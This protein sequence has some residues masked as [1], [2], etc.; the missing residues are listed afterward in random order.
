MR[1]LF[2]VCC[3][4][5]AAF[6][7]NKQES[8]SNTPNAQKGFAT[9][10]GFDTSYSIAA[11]HQPY[12]LTG[13]FNDDQVPDTAVILKEKAGLN[14]VLL[15]KHGN[16]DQVFLLR[17]GKALGQEFNNFNWV[18]QFQLIPKGTKIWNNVVD[19]DLVG[20]EEVPE[21]KKITLTTD[22][23]LIHQAEACGG[24][25]IYFKDGKYQWVQQD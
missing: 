19:G 13:Y 17:N 1:I 2:F 6:C 16:T 18:G 7:G 23:I 3:C 25:I 24:G 20:E 15:I 12:I 8:D 4:M 22:G 21:N 11:N 10:F 5:A 9:L 14:E